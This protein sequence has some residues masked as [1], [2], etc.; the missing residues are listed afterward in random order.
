M[1]QPRSVKMFANY[2][3]KSAIVV[4]VTATVRTITGTNKAEDAGRMDAR[5][6][7]ADALRRVFLT[8][9]ASFSNF[10]TG[11]ARRLC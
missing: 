4:H 2:E 7:S 11:S 5:I 3:R 8:S 10:V 1:T 9:L 6:M